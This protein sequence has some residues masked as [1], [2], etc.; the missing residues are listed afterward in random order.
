MFR[1]R[2]R[3]KDPNGLPGTRWPA[4]CDLR[5]PF[6]CRKL[7]IVE[8]LFSE[9]RSGHPTWHHVKAPVEARYPTAPPPRLTTTCCGAVR[10]CE[11]VLGV[12]PGSAGPIP[13]IG[14]G[15]CWRFGQ[16]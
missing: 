7:N 5:A 13:A 16:G 1:L 6:P 9:V 2:W 11:R 10:R 4:P 3:L 15:V 14:R 12:G 8:H